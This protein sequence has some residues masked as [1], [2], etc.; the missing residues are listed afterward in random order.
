[1]MKAVML[2]GPVGTWKYKS[3]EILAETLSPTCHPT[4]CPSMK[5]HLKKIQKIKAFEEHNVKRQKEVS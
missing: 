2:T 5:R 3:Q 4:S 1:M